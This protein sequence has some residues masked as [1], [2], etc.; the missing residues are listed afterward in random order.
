[1]H[2][3]VPNLNC[4]F[5]INL[6]VVNITGIKITVTF[7]HRLIL[8]NNPTVNGD[9]SFCLNVPALHIP[10][11]HNVATGFDDKPA[12]DVTPDMNRT[13]KINI[14]GLISDIASDLMDQ[15]HRDFI[16]RLGR[17]AVTSGN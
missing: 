1:M 4:S 3:R 8:S 9:V 10:G 11:D 6:G 5:R 2:D 16:P 15:L 13:D 7:D 12:F 17:L 14:P